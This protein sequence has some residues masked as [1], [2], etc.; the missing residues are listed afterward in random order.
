M[1]EMRPS[2]WL[3]QK[4]LRSDWLVPILP[5]ST[6]TIHTIVRAYVCRFFTTTQKKVY[7]IKYYVAYVFVS[8]LDVKWF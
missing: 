4:V 8:A 3:I 2:D 1:G 5:H 7:S 6:T